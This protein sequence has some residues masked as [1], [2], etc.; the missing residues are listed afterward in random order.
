MIG[1]VRPYTEVDTDIPRAAGVVAALFD[2][3]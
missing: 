1:S 3:L 2:E